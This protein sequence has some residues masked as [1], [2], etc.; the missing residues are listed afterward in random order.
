MMQ[1]EGKP[2]VSGFFLYILFIILGI[3]GT[4]FL[5]SKNNLQQTQQMNQQSTS[6]ADINTKQYSSAPKLTIDTKKNYSATLVTSKGNITI[7]LFAK[8]VPNTVN[9]FVFL[10]KE[11]FYNETKFH[12]IVKDFMIQGGDPKG[13]GTGGP[14]YTF[15]DEKITKDYKRGIVAMANSGPNT[16][17]S[18]FFIMHKDT[19]LPK[20][21]VIFGEV[22]SGMDVVDKIANVPTVD[23]GQNEK[24]KPTED[25]VVESVEIIEK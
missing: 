21:Y 15:A 11:N 5:F 14:G 12:R 8:D 18:Q 17:G 6:S 16:N 25:V 3:I 24:S 20:N 2:H 22:N 13:K 7:K 1:G 9:N 19:D 10:S 23:N 4:V